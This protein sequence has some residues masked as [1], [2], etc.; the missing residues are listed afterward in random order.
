M[1]GRGWTWAPAPKGPIPKDVREELAVCL[2]R[3]AE[4]KWGGRVRKILLRFHGVYAYVAAVEAARGEKSPPKVCR[5]IERGEVPVELCRLGY[6]GRWSDR[7]TYAFFKYSD[8]CY[9]PSVVASGSFEATPEQAFDC[10]A[11]VYI[12]V[13]DP[14]RGVKRRPSGKKRQGKRGAT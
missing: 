4:K 5:Y 6:L 12:G 13:D 11:G 10:A 7:W 8:H 3:H 2:L 1:A 14:A 9:A